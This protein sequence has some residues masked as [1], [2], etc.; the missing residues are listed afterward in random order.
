[1]AVW[2]DTNGEMLCALAAGRHANDL[3]NLSIRVGDGISGWVASSGKDLI[4]GNPEFEGAA[5]IFSRFRSVLAIPVE[6]GLVVA[7]YSTEPSAYG[8]EHVT[9]LRDACSV[10][11]S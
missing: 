3:R 11:S 6:P 5:D 2:Q 7:V 8:P 4:S 1:V 10:A 9:A